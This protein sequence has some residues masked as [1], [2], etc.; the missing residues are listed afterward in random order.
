[1]QVPVE[2][3]C[4]S[5]FGVCELQAV[6]N[7]IG[8]DRGLPPYDALDYK[9]IETDTIIQRDYRLCIGCLR[10][11]SVCKN[12]KGADALGFVIEKGRIDSDEKNRIQNNITYINSLKM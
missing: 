1:M 6:S 12:V 11:V 8:I 10:C 9:R 4:C 2:E 3:R 7:Y 5:K